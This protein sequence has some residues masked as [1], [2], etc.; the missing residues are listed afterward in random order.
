MTALFLHT[1][2]DMRAQQLDHSYIKLLKKTA[3][4]HFS[5][6]NAS[7][8]HFVLKSVRGTRAQIKKDCL[9]VL[10]KGHMRSESMMTAGKNKI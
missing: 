10:Q 6:R 7:Q 1:F 9:M 5:H 2:I 8:C 4:Q 3:E